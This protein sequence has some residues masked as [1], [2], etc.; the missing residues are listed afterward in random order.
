MPAGDV[1]RQIVLARRPRG[2]VT[3][4]DFRLVTAPIPTPRPDEVLVRHH[5]LSIDPY[6]RVSVNDGRSCRGVAANPFGPD[7][8][9]IY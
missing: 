5:W 6:V 1:N 7:H 3:P 4:D 2:E 9:R 8:E